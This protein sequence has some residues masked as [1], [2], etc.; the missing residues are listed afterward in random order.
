MARPVLYGSSSDQRVANPKEAIGLATWKRGRFVSADAQAEGGTVTTV[1]MRFSGRR[2]EINALTKEGGEIRVELLDA[3]GQPL[4]AM[5]ISEPFRGDQIR[6]TVRF[7][8]LPSLASLTSRPVS[9]RFHLKSAELY[10]FA[11]SDE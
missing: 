5:K 2:L 1:P 4:A 9:L 3:A 7:D 10:S 8:D 6:Y 11:F